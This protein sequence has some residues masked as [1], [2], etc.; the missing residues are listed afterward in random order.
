MSDQNND[1]KN[2]VELPTRARERFK[3][4]S[5]LRDQRAVSVLSL[6]S[7]VMVCL[8]INQY[9]NLQQEAMSSNKNREVASV[10]G[11]IDVEQNVKWEQQMAQELNGKNVRMIQAVK[12]VE[13]D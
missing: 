2:I 4:Q 10:R 7:V 6:G 12:P 11:S 3:W 1:D 5:R 9:L 13:H 8:L